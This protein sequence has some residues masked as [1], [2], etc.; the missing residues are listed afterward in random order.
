MKLHR[1]TKKPDWAKVARARRNAWQR[2][3]NTTK[4]SVTPGNILTIV[5]LAITT[6]GLVAVVQRQYSL[7]VAAL[8]VG[9]LFDLL[10]G[11]VADKTGTKGPVG[12]L[13]DAS[14]DKLE[15]LAALIILYFTSVVP[16]WA[17][18]ALAW[19]HVW[20]ALIVVTKHMQRQR[21]HPSRLG[22]VSMAL[23]WFAIG[24]FV[25]VKVL[26]GSVADVCSVVSYALTLSSLILGVRAAW[27]YSYVTHKKQL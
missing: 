22:K 13:L 11:W 8:L 2:V 16:A 1:A 19:P 9:R 5:G 18:V 14:I 23:A 21:L 20:I 10:D 25:L 3:A 6:V 24:G 26:H 12:E 4:G 27:S 15:V 7:A 17:I